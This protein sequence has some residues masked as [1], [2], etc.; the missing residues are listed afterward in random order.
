MKKFELYA[1]FAMFIV[2]TLI[3]LSILFLFEESILGWGILA[4]VSV[5]GYLTSY[6][7]YDMYKSKT[8]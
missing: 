6:L 4:F 1:A 3:I 2:T 5:T 8:H 7:Y